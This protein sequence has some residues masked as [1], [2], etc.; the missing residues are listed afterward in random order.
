M[1]KMALTIDGNLYARLFIEETYTP[2]TGSTPGPTASVAPGDYSGLT[3]WF[4]ADQLSASYSQSQAVN[5][6]PSYTSSS[7]YSASQANASLQ[8]YYTETDFPSGNPSVYFEK[9]NLD[10]MDMVNTNFG[11]TMSLSFVSRPQ[12]TVDA[13]FLSYNPLGTLNNQIRVWNSNLATQ[14]VM[15]YTNGGAVVVTANTFSS[16]TASPRLATIVMNPGALKTIKIYEGHKVRGEYVNG[17]SR[18]HNFTQTN[19]NYLGKESTSNTYCFTGSMAEFCAYRS[20]SLT[21]DNLIDLYEQYWRPKYPDL[22]QLGTSASSAGVDPTTIDGHR[23]SF[24]ADDSSSMQLTG[25]G[26][27]KVYAWSSSYHD[28]GG[29]Y[30]SSQATSTLWPTLE[31]NVMNGHA[32]VYFFY[33][34]TATNSNFL[35]MD[36]NALTGSTVSGSEVFYVC[37]RVNVT[38]GATEYTLTGAPTNWGGATVGAS[39]HHTWVTL[40][41]YDSHFSDTRFNWTQGRIGEMANRYVLNFAVGNGSTG[42]YQV[43]FN[44]SASYTNTATFTPRWISAGSSGPPAHQTVIGRGTRDNTGTYC[45]WG[46]IMEIVHFSRKLTSQERTDVTN[47]LR[48]KYKIYDG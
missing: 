47:W 22:V 24:I 5:V 41:Y 29:P 48:T 3:W 2:I 37:R 46:H 6:W 11:I 4:K 39:N 8:P 30:T 17:V 36:F 1:A 26:N 38:V 42:S 45:Y 19:F 23:F 31:T 27:D 43:F 18:Y 21:E 40:D 9:A 35:H 12:P 33:D 7:F 16:S 10:R 15:F 13:E 44:G 14:P 20:S 32:G 34:G 25:S 28:A